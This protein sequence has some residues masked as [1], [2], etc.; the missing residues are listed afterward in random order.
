MV[1]PAA[2]SSHVNTTL[3]RNSHRLCEMGS[4]SCGGLHARAPVSVSS[5]LC[6]PAP[7]AQV[8]LLADPHGELARGLGLELEAKEM[9]G[10]NRSKRYSA[11]VQDNEITAL[12]VEPDGSGERAV[13]HPKLTVGLCWMAALRGWHVLCLLLHD[14]GKPILC[15]LFGRLQVG[16]CSQCSLDTK[17]SC[18]FVVQARHARCRTS[19][20]TS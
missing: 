15:A 3:A 16:N 13:C 8:Q 5:T 7:G 11:I 10:T 14:V 6:C 18:V 17:M 12:N 2:M 4:G 19:S 9:L 1:A 20:S